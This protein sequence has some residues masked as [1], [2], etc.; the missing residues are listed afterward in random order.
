MNSIDLEIKAR[1]AGKVKGR[2]LPWLNQWQYGRELWGDENFAAMLDNY[3]SW[4]YVASSKN[5]TTVANVPLRLYVAKNKKSSI[6]G[7]PTKKVEK[8][9]EIM[10]R[11]N[12]FLSNISAVRKAV[13]FEEILDHSFLDLKNNVNNFQ[14]GMDLMELTQLYQELTGNSFWHIKEDKMGIPRELW[15]VPPQSC[16]IIPD[17]EKFISG[18]KYIKGA[19][20]ITLAEREIIHFKMANPKSVYY[21][22][23]PF[24]SVAEE[25][26]LN[27]SINTYEDAIFKNGGNNLSGVFETDS[28]LSDHEFERLKL[29][30]QQAFGGAK[31]GGIMPLLDHGLKFKPVGSSPKEMSHLGGRAFVKEAILNAYGQALGMYSAEANRANSEAAIATYM[32]FTIAPRLKRMEQKINEKL[33]WRYDEKL[34]LMY[35]NCIPSDKE[36]E[37]N[38]R[39]KHSQSGIESINEIR[40]GL[41][42]AKFDSRFDEPIIPVNYTVIDE[43]LSRVG[44]NKDAQN[45]IDNSN[46]D[47]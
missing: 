34:F 10:I 32:Q 1:S 47:A 18:Y 40:A 3:K 9:Q 16:K 44:A 15:V 2:S 26:G 41:G 12:A 31:R 13:E 5:A 20:E 30:I 14:N 4:V 29:E 23:A 33:I 37:L 43:I 27:K 38:Q 21:G 7:Y 46:N 28:D 6:K 35:D 36:F 8:S 19:E 39:I 11:E 22:V 45:K 17:K 24:V 42:K 25:Y